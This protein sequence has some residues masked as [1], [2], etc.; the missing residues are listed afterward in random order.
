M[1][2][3]ENRVNAPAEKRIS[4]L[5]LYVPENLD[6]DAIIRQHP[7]DFEPFHRDCLLYICHLIT[8]IA[9]RRKDIKIEERFGFT[10]VNRKYLQSR[11]HDYRRYVDYLIDCGV[12]EES[13]QYIVGEKSRGLRFAPAFLREIKPITITKWTLI[14]SISRLR[15]E[16]REEADR[17]LSHLTKWWDHERLKV[18][19]EGATTLLRAMYLA[20]V[21][22][23]NVKHPM[24]RLNARLLPLQELSRGNFFWGADS[25]AG[26]FHTLLTQLKSETRRFL[27]YDGK[28]LCNVDIVNSQPFFTLALLDPELVAKNNMI[29][30]VLR[31]NERL[32]KEVDKTLDKPLEW[33]SDYTPIPIFENPS[34]SSSLKEL[35][36]E[37]CDEEDV[38]LFRKLVVDGTFYEEFGEMLKTNATL[39]LSDGISFRAKAKALTFRS[40]FSANFLVRE[41]SEM[42]DFKNNFPNVFRVFQAVKRGRKQHP[43]LAKVLQNLEAE[44]VLHRACKRIAELHPEVPIFTIHDSIVTTVDNGPLVKEIFSEVIEENLGVR[45]QFKIEKWE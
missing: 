37:V 30:R 27:T 2:S 40:F 41:G 22:D 17:S 31:Y 33:I 13:R 43:S 25:T 7:P 10:P 35:I 9:S 15:T 18:D 45:P 38:Q 44:I 26:R 32:R 34:I 42:M 4:K 11:I 28:K 14:K 6:I 1:I 12:I 5:T 20:D 24:K 29:G 19:L 39:N 16:R 23:E 3:G 36:W 21:A 8:A